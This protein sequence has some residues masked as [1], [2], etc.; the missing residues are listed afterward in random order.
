MRYSLTCLALLYSASAASM[1]PA[2]DVQHDLAKIGNEIA[3]AHCGVKAKRTKQQ[4]KNLFEES[5]A[6]YRETIQCK[7]LV[8][9]VYHANIYKPP[10]QILESLTLRGAHAMLPALVSPGS[11]REAVLTYAGKPMQASPISIVYLLANEG[12]D[13]HTAMFTFANGKLTSI[14]W[15]WSSQ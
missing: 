14:A 13:Q 11:T 8:L 9:V 12:P 10:H 2:P 6:D 1:E 3:A 5:V 7:G 15:R 4:V